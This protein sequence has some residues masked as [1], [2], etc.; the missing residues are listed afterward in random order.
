MP[1]EF[2]NFR[3]KNKIRELDKLVRGRE[4]RGL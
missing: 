2:L 1:F 4:G 3:I